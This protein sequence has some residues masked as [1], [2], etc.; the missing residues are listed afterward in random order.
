MIL[1]FTGVRDVPRPGIFGG[2]RMA[3]DFK[4]IRKNRNGVGY[5]TY[6]YAVKVQKSGNG[7]N[8][9]YYDDA[10]HSGTLKTAYVSYSVHDIYGTPKK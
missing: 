7:C 5:V 2:E 10:N 9:S 4:V 8:I 6:P 1:T 3:T